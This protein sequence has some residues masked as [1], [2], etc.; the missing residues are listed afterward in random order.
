[1]T[2]R[3]AE[4]SELLPVESAGFRAQRLPRELASID[5]SKLSTVEVLEHFRAQHE[6]AR[7]ARQAALTF[8]PRVADRV[9]E[10]SEPCHC[11]YAKVGEECGGL[12]PCMVR[13]DR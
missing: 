2:T 4:A 1:M 8:R 6:Q 10:L 7:S 11:C 3:P 5:L 13:G 9:R 12:A